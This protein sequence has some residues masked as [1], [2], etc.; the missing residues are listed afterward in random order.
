MNIITF[1][2][3]ELGD[4][5]KRFKKDLPVYSV[6]VSDER[7]KYSAGERLMT[8]WGDMVA[9][10]GKKEVSGGLPGLKSAYEYFDELD[11]KMIGELKGYEDM[12]ILT[13]RK[14]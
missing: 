5:K 8:E 14:I 13:I 4:I 7:G 12:D 3:M 1:P 2:E 10:V 6:R 9:V 11:D